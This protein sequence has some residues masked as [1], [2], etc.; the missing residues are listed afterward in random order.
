[1]PLTLCRCHGAQGRGQRYISMPYRRGGAGELGRAVSRASGESDGGGEGSAGGSTV[2]SCRG[3]QECPSV[4]QGPGA[5][6]EP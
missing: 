2:L 6:E 3:R 4:L 1:M 5:T